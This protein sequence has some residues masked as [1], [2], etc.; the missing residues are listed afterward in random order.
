MV[1]LQILGD[2]AKMAQRSRVYTRG[3]SGRAVLETLREELKARA[4]GTSGMHCDEIIATITQQQ[5]RNGRGS[6]SKNTKR[7]RGI[8][9]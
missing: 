2:D 9:R 7:M 5:H 3:E 6:T 1:G 8:E 4:Q